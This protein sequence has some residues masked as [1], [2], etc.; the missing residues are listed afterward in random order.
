MDSLPTVVIIQL[1]WTFNFETISK[2]ERL[3]YVHQIKLE[4]C[5]C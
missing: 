2:W 4:S 5:R 1:T 3:L